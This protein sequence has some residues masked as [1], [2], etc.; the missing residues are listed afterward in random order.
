MGST[1]QNTAAP[2]YYKT[3]GADTV[4]RARDNYAFQNPD[5]FFADSGYSNWDQAA[6]S[7]QKVQGTVYKRPDNDT[8]Y[9][10]NPYTG[11]SH[12]FQRPDQF[13]GAGYDWGQI[14]TTTGDP[15][16]LYG[17]KYW[18][19]QGYD[20]SGETSAAYQPI[21]EAY[22]KRLRDLIAPVTDAYGAI[23]DKQ[24]SRES[25]EDYYRQLSG[26]YG[27]D[28]TRD[29]LTRVRQQMLGTQGLMESLPGDVA[30]TTKDFQVTD[31][32][33]RL[34]VGH[35]G[36][37]LSQQLSQQSRAHDSAMAG[38]DLSMDAV[39]RA[40]GLRREQEGRELDPLNTNLDSSRFAFDQLSESERS[41]L[42]AMLAG[43]ESDVNRRWNV[44]DLASARSQEME[45]RA[46]EEALHQRL[47]DEGFEDLERQLQIEQRYARSSGG[48]VNPLQQYKAQQQYQRAAQA[49]KT[50][51]TRK[52]LSQAATGINNMTGTVSSMLSRLTGKNINI[53]KLS[54]PS[55]INLPSVVN[56]LAGPMS[57][58]NQKAFIDYVNKLS[59]VK[60][61]EYQYREVQDGGLKVPI[62]FNPNNPAA[63]VRLDNLLP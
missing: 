26:D 19:A 25:I 31:A 32:G 47:R 59:E 28:D 60:G 15:T 35:K 16:A 58:A 52:T 3:A 17:K 50:N 13:T 44:A 11:S 22:D 20:A 62:A 49:A 63:S 6:P 42:A 8:V 1:I 40:L 4:Y 27:L 5:E 51:P 24:A 7:I 36:A 30:D 34:Q 14:Q 54:G 53:P 33:R 43:T 38:Y 56:R 29:L 9:E 45:D 46:Y 61:V 37:G 55:Q 2:K 48:T 12:A 18:N 57:T 23:S 10:Y 21:I 39:E 41:A